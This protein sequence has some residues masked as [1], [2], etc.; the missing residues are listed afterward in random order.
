MVSP[1]PMETTLIAMVN[2]WATLTSPCVLVL[3]FRL[4]RFHFP[5]I[6]Y[7][8][9]VRPPQGTLCTAVRTDSPGFRYDTSGGHDS[10]LR[11]G[12]HVPVNIPRHPVGTAGP[13]KAPRIP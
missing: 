10:R 9:V 12:H 1:P 11:R 4:S 13:L 5:A 6:C 8:Q 7:L 3:P 2:R